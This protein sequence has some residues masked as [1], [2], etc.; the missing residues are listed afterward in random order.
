MSENPREAPTPC[1][2]S[3]P[4]TQ[5]GLLLLQKPLH[6]SFPLHYSLPH[7]MAISPKAPFQGFTPPLILPQNPNSQTPHFQG[8]NPVF[9]PYD[10]LPLTPEHPKS[11]GSGAQ[12][13]LPP[14]PLPS[15]GPHLWGGEPLL[16]PAC[17]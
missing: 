9:P 10:P 1:R 11:R 6:L 13:R 5:A 17:D 7:L 2:T 3:L 4:E 8:L 12:T 16:P 14:S 15:K